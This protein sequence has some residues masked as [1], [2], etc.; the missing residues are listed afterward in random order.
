MKPHG[1]VGSNIATPLA[2]GDDVPEDGIIHVGDLLS[3][4]DDGD[5]TDIKPKTEVK[6]KIEVAGGGGGSGGAGG[7][8]R[9]VTADVDV[10]HLVSIHIIW[11]GPS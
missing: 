5:N 7:S 4:F 3:P 11:H 6:P 9:L 1:I 8:V 2:F 10:I